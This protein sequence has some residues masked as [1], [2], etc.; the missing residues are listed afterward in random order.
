MARRCRL[1]VCGT[2]SIQNLYEFHN[3]INKLSPLQFT[4]EIKNNSTMNFLDLEI[5]YN[6]SDNEITRAE[7]HIDRYHFI[8]TIISHFKL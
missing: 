3:K 2:D 5:T 8:K 7:N 6:K 4:L 1:C